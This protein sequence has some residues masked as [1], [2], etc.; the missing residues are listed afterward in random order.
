[1]KISVIVHMN[2][3]AFWLVARKGHEAM[4]E[5]HSLEMPLEVA[6]EHPVNALNDMTWS[7]IILQHCCYDSD[8]MA[9]D[10]IGSLCRLYSAVIR[11]SV[12]KAQEEERS[13]NEDVQILDVLRN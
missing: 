12:A 5:E 13:Y 11:R 7:L 4:E 1:M 3:I 2:N 10:V 8:L 6:N 9:P